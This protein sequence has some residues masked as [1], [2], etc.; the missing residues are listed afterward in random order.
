MGYTSAGLDLKDLSGK[1]EILLDEGGLSEDDIVK[2]MTVNTATILGIDKTH[3]SLESGKNASFSVFDKPM[4]EEKATVLHTIS[5]GII[6][7]FEGN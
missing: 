1:L 5:N 2:L 7:E 3:G 6:H 4:S